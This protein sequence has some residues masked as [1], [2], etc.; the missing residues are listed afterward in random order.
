MRSREIS[1]IRNL[2]KKEDVRQRETICL[3]ASENYISQ[4]VKEALSSNI[5]NKYAEGIPYKRHYP[6][7][8]IADKL[9]EYGEKLAKKLFKTDEANLQPY[10]GSIANLIAFKAIL[11][12]GDI[13][14][15][16][17]PYDGGHSTHA[18]KY[19]ISG[20]IYKTFF[21]RVNR[22]GLI[23]YDII[24][25]SAKK[26]R[27]TLIIA[28]SSFYPQEI[29]YKSFYEIA[30]EV[31][32][33]FLA[34]IAHPAG[35]IAAN[36]HNSPAEYAD[37]ITSTTHKTLRGPRGGLIMFKSK[38]KRA[39]SEALYPGVQGGPLLN[40]IAAK[41]IA[42]AEALDESFIKYQRMVVHNTMFLCQLL[43]EL[44]FKLY[45][46]G[47]TNHLIIIDLKPVGIN[48]SQIEKELESINI[49]SNALPVPGRDGKTADGL[50]IGTA[51]ITTLGYQEC[52]LQGIA[53]ILYY[54]II[55]REIDRASKIQKSIIRRVKNY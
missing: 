31:G 24:R 50:R 51:A 7:C 29:N 30:K 46:G 54:I 14:L 33:Y 27:P 28:G 8:M 16:M 6:G 40:V 20:Q 48:A 17:H 43:K 22:D 45:T 38:F 41:A 11:K 13:V 32:A 49:T 4:N 21:Y 36:L 1:T 42:F 18:T 10:S 35:L 19:N 15:A 34:D 47:S 25:R 12:K 3:I 2:L 52:D 44:G 23:D 55:K 9:E 5:I 39:V 53:E 26:T 37:I